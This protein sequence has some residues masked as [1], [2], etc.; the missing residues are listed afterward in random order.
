MVLFGRKVTLAE[1]EDIWDEVVIAFAQRV[2]LW[3]R[4][5]DIDIV[6][7]VRV[8]LVNDGDGGPISSRVVSVFNVCKVNFVYWFRDELM[9]DDNGCSWPFG[10]VYV[11]EAVEGVNREENEE[12]GD[13][14]D[15]E[16]IIFVW[17]TTGDDDLQ[18]ICM[19][20]CFCC[21]W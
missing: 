8:V 20:F 5:G 10:Q 11:D 9:G 2:W 14:D 1:E 21:W 15:D 4:L 19:E 12:I 16:E 13:D 17:E 7:T 6:I 3:W 18:S